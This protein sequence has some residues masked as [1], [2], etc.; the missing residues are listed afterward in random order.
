M[1]VALA[2]PAES[3]VRD[4]IKKTIITAKPQRHTRPGVVKI[5]K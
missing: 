2:D 5:L 3:F 1:Y 4:G